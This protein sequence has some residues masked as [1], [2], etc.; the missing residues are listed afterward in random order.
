MTHSM[1]YSPAGFVTDQLEFPGQ[2][3][4]FLSDGLGILGGSMMGSTPCTVYIESAAGIEVSRGRDCGR[5]RVTLE[6]RTGRGPF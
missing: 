3:W 2:M 4:A 5:R 1:S 6:G